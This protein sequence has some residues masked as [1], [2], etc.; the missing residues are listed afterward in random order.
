MIHAIVTQNKI[1][2]G[3]Y[4][5]YNGLRQFGESFFKSICCWYVLREVQGSGEEE[6][7]D[8]DFLVQVDIQPLENISTAILDFMQNAYIT[9]RPWYYNYREG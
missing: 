3:W 7:G 6:Q 2:N 1:D 4:P 8:W 5:A 9:R